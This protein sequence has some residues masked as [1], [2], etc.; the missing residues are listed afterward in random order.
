MRYGS[1]TQSIELGTNNVYQSCRETPQR[2][3]KRFGVDRLKRAKVGLGQ[4]SSD[5]SGGTLDRVH[6]SWSYCS[7]LGFL[8]LKSPVFY[9]SRSDV[10]LDH[11]QQ[12]LPN[13]H[14]RANGQ[15]TWPTV[16]RRIG[17]VWCH[18]AM[19][20]AQSYLALG[21]HG[22]SPVEHQTGSLRPQTA[23]IC[24]FLRKEAIAP[25][26]PSP[27][28]AASR[29][30]HL[31]PRISKSNTT[32]EHNPTTHT[33]GFS[34]IQ[35]PVMSWSCKFAYLRSCHHVSCICC[36]DLLLYVYFLSLPYSNL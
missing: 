6:E 8:L 9:Y 27:I 29:C 30:L 33:S 5:W 12:L 25:W 14:K 4:T 23:Q 28:Q 26:P 18:L 1:H 19:E 21:V 24:S 10:L 35:A 3:P 16:Q 36:C 15:L 22:P 2:Q 13:G 31:V 7:V 32:L 20:S 34:E 11:I 17:P